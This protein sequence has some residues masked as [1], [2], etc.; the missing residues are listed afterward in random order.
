[1]IVESLRDVVDGRS[2]SEDRAYAVM[3]QIMDG[4]ATPAQIGGL[5]AAMRAKRET[6]DEI[7]GF[8]RA[9]REHSVRVETH[10]RPLV[11]TCGTGGD[12]KGTFNV[13]TTAA[14]V[15]A[16]AG[17]AVAKHGNRAASSRCG[18]A[19]VLEALGVNLDLTAAQVGACIDE[20]GIGFLFAQRHHPAMKHAAQPRRELGIRTV[21]NVLGPLTNPACAAHQV[22]G[23]FDAGLCPMLAEALGRLGSTEAM[24]VHGEDGLDEISVCARTCVSHL[25]RGRVQT[26]ALDARD[27]LP[28]ASPPDP[29]ALRGGES[30]AENA[31]ILRAVLAGES[32]PRRDIVLLNA[33][34]ALV[35]AGAADGWQGALALAGASIDSGAAARTLDD[36]ITTTRR[37]LP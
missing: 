32:G 3:S 18:S 2:L 9:M 35:T 30:P 12:G 27:L 29:Q 7:V 11:D 16:G 17:V 34:A 8:A 13:S 6:I 25:V 28:G 21:F 4:E 24:V 37:Y 22:L 23:V 36:L 26:Q 31:A 20:V 1:M 5:L 19:D 15:V 33:A 10:R 14:F